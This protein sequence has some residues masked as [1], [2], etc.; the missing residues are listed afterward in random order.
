L[1][2]CS[3]SLQTLL[4]ANFFLSCI[5]FCA[6]Q[7]ALFEF[8]STFVIVNTRKWQRENWIAIWALDLASSE[9]EIWRGKIAIIKLFIVSINVIFSRSIKMVKNVYGKFMAIRRSCWF[10]IKTKPV[11]DFII[12]NILI[13]DHVRGLNLK[14]N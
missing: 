5:F 13:F 6:S 2:N 4:Y 12:L 1:H 7:T 11:E 10:S 9:C 8:K 14:L 3:F